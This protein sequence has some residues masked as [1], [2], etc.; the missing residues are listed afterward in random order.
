MFFIDLIVLK[1]HNHQTNC[2]IS[3]KS[4]VISDM[5]PRPIFLRIQKSFT[6]YLSSI[7]TDW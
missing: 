6:F 5:L 3:M 4:D 1:A 7:T 2:Y